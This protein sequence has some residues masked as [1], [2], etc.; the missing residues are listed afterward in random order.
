MVIDLSKIRPASVAPRPIDPIEIFQSCKVSDPSIN[1]L[2]LAQGDALREYHR[3]R[4]DSDITI[5]LNTGA[6]KTLV[7]LLIA[8][9]LVNEFSRQVVYACA[10]IQLIEQTQEKATGYGLD[11]TTYHSGQFSDDGYRSS[12]KPCL[13][14]YQA[15]FNG[16]TIFRRDD[17]GAVIFDDAHTADQI[18]REQF[19]LSIDREQLK[20]VYNELYSEFA[21][22]HTEIGRDISYKEMFNGVSNQVFWIPPNVVYSKIHRVKRILM[23]ATLSERVETMF[24]WQHLHDSIDRC[25]VLISSRSITLTPPFVPVRTL[26]YFSADVRRVYLSATLDARDSFARTFG[27][28]P[29]NSTLYK[30]W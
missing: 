11:V 30:G 21:N 18:L 9:S 26:P 10:S 17:I 12:T 29:T 22:Y 2:W 7:G 19:T 4:R 1:D 13:T 23:E 5:A 28:V 15:L 3:C 8:Q 24:A 6:G 25:C 14:T 27:C 20:S 16:K